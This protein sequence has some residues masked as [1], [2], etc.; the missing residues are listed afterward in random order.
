MRTLQ[1]FLLS[2]P[3]FSLF[4]MAQMPSSLNLM[5]APA[6]VQVGTGLLFVDQSFTAVLESCVHKRSPHSTRP[7][8]K[9]C[10]CYRSSTIATP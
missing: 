2:V 10:L 7:Q 6:R 3:L 1:L 5:P 8:I 4:A 9:F